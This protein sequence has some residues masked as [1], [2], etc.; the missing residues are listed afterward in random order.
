MPRPAP[1]LNEFIGHKIIIGYL[2]DLIEG[3][4]ARG[5]PF[6]DLLLTGPSGSGKTLLARAVAAEYGTRLITAMG[7][8]PRDVLAGKLI[9]LSKN[10]FLFIDECHQLDC[11][12]QEMLRV[13]IDERYVPDPETRGSDPKK[14]PPARVALQ[15]FTLILATDQPGQLQ[16]ALRK[17]VRVVSLTYYSVN[18]LKDVVALMASK[19]KLLVSPQAARRIAEVSSGLPRLAQ[20]HLRD[21]RVLFPDAEQRKLGLDDI[22][23]YLSQA[24]FDEHGLN[25]LQRRYLAFLNEKGAASIETIALCLGTDT[26]FVRQ[27]IEPHLVLSGLVTI[28]PAGRRLTHRGQVLAASPQ[29]SDTPPLK[30]KEETK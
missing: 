3:A 29:D 20:M 6:P 16:K 8:E 28:G 5:E 22:R 19:L 10:D 14:C 27:E 1:R 11:L 2:R 13:A 17:R 23:R 9:A 7:D 24:G 12:D 26:D 30:E 4:I 18:E 21:V 15:P 25:G